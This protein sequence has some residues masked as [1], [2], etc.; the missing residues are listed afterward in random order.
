MLEA[1][2]TLEWRYPVISQIISSLVL[3][4]SSA[5]ATVEVNSY[6]VILQK[7]SHM[8]RQISNA[9]AIVE[10]NVLQ[11]VEKL[12]QPTPAHFLYARE[13]GIS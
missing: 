5:V 13:L 7:L 11:F 4:E 12:L 10:A 2:S 6:Q 3:P 8:A 1:P 9:V